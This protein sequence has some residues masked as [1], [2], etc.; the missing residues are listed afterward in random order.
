M[1]IRITE[2]QYGQLVEQSIREKL[3]L[4]A[5][6][7]LMKELGLDWDEIKAFAE[8][9]KNPTP[10][11]FE[12]LSKLTKI[13][14]KGAIKVAK[15]FADKECDCD[16]I[17][18]Q[19][20]PDLYPI[21]IIGKVK[22]YINSCYGPRWGKMHSG[23]D[24]DTSTINATN[25][26]LIATCAGTVIRASDSGN[27]GGYIKLKCNNKDAV[28]YCHLVVV[29][30][31]LYGLKVPQGFPIGISG[32]GSDEVGAGNSLGPHLHYITW[33]GG[34]KINPILMIAGGETIPAGGKV[35]KSKDGQ[36]CDPTK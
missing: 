5:L 25:Q 18:Q 14:L 12:L 15:Y 17:D 3:A 1:K 33:K 4:K 16:S 10:K 32:G 34:K 24:L 26:P 7:L 11:D 21:P 35:N 22:K 27:C 23:V 28:G 30:D 8:R 19:S 6:K 9:M 2:N 20:P 13:Q 31:N 36:F 29:N